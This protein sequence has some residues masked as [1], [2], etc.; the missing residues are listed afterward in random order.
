MSKGAI[1]IKIF[2]NRQLGGV[3]ELT[4]GVRFGTVDM[5]INSSSAM[6]D[7]IPQIDALQLPFLINSYADFAKLAMTPE[8]EALS[9]GLAC[10]GAIALAIYEGGQRHFLTV[11]R[12]VKSIEDSRV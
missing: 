1:E 8:A 6:A 9:P 4:E 3:K 11:K 5:T 10:K 12:E 7:L 2:P